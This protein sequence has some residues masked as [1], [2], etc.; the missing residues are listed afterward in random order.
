MNLPR[1][2]T[3]S[4]SLV[5]RFTPVELEVNR[6]RELTKAH[7]HAEALGALDPLLAEFPE[8]RDALSIC[9]P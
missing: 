4:N 7:R 3:S 9:R 5:M 2:C 6:I 8:N 1:S